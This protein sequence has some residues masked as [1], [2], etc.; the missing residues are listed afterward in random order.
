MKKF[1]KE[2]YHWIVAVVGL[3]QLF[4]YGGII[5]NFS[6]YHLIPVSEALGISRTQFAL[7]NTTRSFIAIFG[8]LL[9]GAL[10]GRIGYRKSAALCLCLSTVANILFAVMNSFWML[11]LGCACMGLC[12]GICGA[13]GI[14]Q[15][16]NLWFHRKRGF[17]LGIIT[18]ATGL[19]SATLGFVQAYAIEH[20]SWRYSFGFAALVLFLSAALMFLLVRDTPEEMGLKPYGE[21]EI[22]VK[23]RSST[24][25][26]G[27]SL[28]QIKRH[29]GFI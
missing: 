12:G 22:A 15:M 18:A 11:V 9:S 13:A 20:L 14:S 7:A 25:W 6:G 3:L 8:N 2:N 29:P 27:L 17:V 5:N 16:I 24:A 19:G 28:E 21:G 26:E 23:K 10:I 4:T 1:L